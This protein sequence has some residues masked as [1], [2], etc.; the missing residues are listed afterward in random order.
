M[1]TLFTPEQI[2]S[3]RD[4]FGEY[5]HVA[6]KDAYPLDASEAAILEAY[7]TKP[8]ARTRSFKE[9]AH[10]LYGIESR[11][12]PQLSVIVDAVGRLAEGLGR[13]IWPVRPGT[14]PYLDLIEMQPAA[15]GK[16]H[17][18][19]PEVVEAVGVT[20]LRGISTLLDHTLVPGVV[21]FMDPYRRPL[22]Q[23][24]NL[25]DQERIGLV[26]AAEE[27]PQTPQI[28]S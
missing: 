25:S 6:F 26:V 23:G 2:D 14:K 4:H 13:H 8:R 1:P 3:A 7:A 28:P 9:K 17:R 19:K 5:G 12:Q 24:I 21:A 22:H 15:V 18:D 10:R 20:T 11:T 16:L 27:P